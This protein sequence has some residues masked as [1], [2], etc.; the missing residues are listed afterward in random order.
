MLT[1]YP[2]NAHELRLT[3]DR[4]AGMD[5]RLRQLVQADI[6]L[7][8]ANERLIRQA[9]YRYSMAIKAI[10][11]YQDSPQYCI[12]LAAAAL[13]GMSED[14]P[15]MEGDNISLRMCQWICADRFC[16]LASIVDASRTGS[17]VEAVISARLRRAFGSMGL[18]EE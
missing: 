15:L 3:G 5:R 18:R 11:K 14:E 1:P 9:C 2:H 6:I 4:Y 13:S 8:D 10:A 17:D 7:E 16:D 12:K